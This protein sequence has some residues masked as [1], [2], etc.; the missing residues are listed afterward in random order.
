[1]SLSKLVVAFV[2][3]LIGAILALC[4]CLFEVAK[5][6]S[7]L[8]PQKEEISKNMSMTVPIAAGDMAKR[9]WLKHNVKEDEL[10]A[11]EQYFVEF[12]KAC[13]RRGTFPAILYE[14]SE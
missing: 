14:K 11:E 2:I 13:I 9:L 4:I 7:A 12:I 6:K 1:M 5:K 8:Y 3:P 10:S